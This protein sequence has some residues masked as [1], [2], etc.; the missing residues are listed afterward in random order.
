MATTAPAP[1]DLTA[2]AERFRGEI[3]IPGSPG[4]EE[5]R[6]VWNGSI[7]RRPAVIARC[8]GVAD[9]LTAVGFARESGLTVAVRSGGH[10]F[11]GLS[12]C[13]DG[14]VIDLSP[15]RGVR[16][17]PDR[18]TV[19]AQA[20]VLLGD[21]DHET[22]AFGKAVPSGIVTHTGIAGLTL[23]GGIGWL[24]RAHGLTIDHLRSVDVVTAGGELVRA[25][26]E[27]NPDLFWGVRG[28]GGNF[29]IVTEFEYDLVDVGPTVL[30]GPIFWPVEE[31]SKVL[32]FYRDWIADAPEDLMTIV[33]HRRAPALPVIPSDLHGRHVTAVMAC[34]AGS[35]DD[36]ERVVEPLRRLG[37]PLLDLCRPKPFVTHQAT[38][39]PSFQHGWHYYVRSRDLGP[40]DDELIDIFARHAGQIRSPL[41]S[42]NYFHVGDGAASRADGDASA[43]PGRGAMHT[44]NING[45]AATAEEHAAEREW[46]HRFYD[47]LE[48]YGVGVYTNFLMAEGEDRVRRAYGAEKYRRLQEVKARWD[49]ENLFHLNQNVVPAAAGDGVSRAPGVRTAG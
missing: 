10:S 27:E 4:Y 22:Q 6:R 38:F 15:M 14:L 17:S 33:V 37:S 32:R 1:V 16:V 49:P 12:T 40:L 7:D 24:T 2:L 25:S 29:G 28:G 18:R 19:R 5:H 11:P 36:G 39:D 48:P 20:G 45:N 3:L 30:A 43:F 44:L 46:V 13:D 47:E 41:S 26:A 8:A 35:V 42:F 23:G 9:V 34:W 21:L 31:T